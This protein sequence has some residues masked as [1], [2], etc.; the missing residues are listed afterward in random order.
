MAGG[1]LYGEDYLAYQRNRGLLRQLVRGVYLRNAAR[2]LVGPTVDLG[3][4]TDDLLR[5]LPT[6]S[7]GLEYNPAAVAHCRALG[8]DV[9][10][11]DGEADGWTLSMLDPAQ[12]YRS[13]VMSHVLEHLPNPRRVL[14][15][16]MLA[17][18][19]IG[20][21]RVLAIVP[22]KAGFALDPTHV[23]FVDQAMLADPALASGTGFRLS[24]SRHFPGDARILGDWLPHHELQAV[25]TKQNR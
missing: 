16:L 10:Y 14:R 12:G 21:E 23:V 4:G 6:G 17:C 2:Q 8:L 11:Y 13:L 3:C 5:R 24:R 18:S 9:A 20:I 19:R 1:D 22:G 25:F 7:R 15:A